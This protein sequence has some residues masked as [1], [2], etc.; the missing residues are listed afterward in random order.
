MWIETFTILVIFQVD[1]DTE[2]YIIDHMMLFH[3]YIYQCTSELTSKYEAKVSF[4]LFCRNIAANL[5][6]DV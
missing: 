1:H 5:V 4:F 6:C 2:V 3:Q